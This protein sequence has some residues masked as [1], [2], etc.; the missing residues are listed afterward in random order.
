MKLLLDTH[1]WL[2]WNTE[3]ERLASKARAQIA[4]PTNGVFLSA[5]SVWEMAIKRRLGKLPL[6]EPVATYVARRLST[7]DIHA[8]PVT[9]EHAAA[10]ETLELVHR[11]PFDRL[12]VVQARYEGMRLLTVDE[13]VLAYGAPTMDVRP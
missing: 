1:V 4:D 13:Q 5:A 10:V 3:P 8:M 6:P 11:D 7:D 2:W 9:C 12:L